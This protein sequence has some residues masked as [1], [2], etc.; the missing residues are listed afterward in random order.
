MR[1]DELFPLRVCINL[2]RRP[3]RWRRMQRRFARHRL[4]PVE[5]FPAVDG[6]ALGAPAGWTDPPGSYGCLL[7][8]LAVVRE[9]RRRGAP[10]V[11]IFEDDVVFHPEIQERF[12]AC[13]GQIPADWDMLLLG[14]LHNGEPVAVAPNL[15]RLT[16][17]YSTY[18][19]GLRHTLYDA[20]LDL[21]LR[22]PSPV[23]YN[24]TL[25]Q[26][27]FSCYCLMPHLAWVEDGYSDAQGTM[28]EHWYLRE[29]M[30]LNGREVERA[31]SRT[32]VI[33]PYAGGRADAAG[34]RLLRFTARH[35]RE[36]L[37]GAAVVVVTPRE[38]PAPGPGR[39]PAGCDL[40]R[41]PPGHPCEPATCCDLAGEALGGERPLLLV[42]ANGVC[43]QPP[44]LRAGLLMGERHDFVSP[45]RELV[46]LD[47]AATRAMLAG[48]HVDTSIHPVRRRGGLCGAGTWLISRSGLDALGGLRGA[49]S[50]RA[51]ARR[52]RQRLRVFEAPGKALRLHRGRVESR[53]T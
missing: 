5:R 45:F 23:D 31:Q 11:L 26:R 21:N 27:D 39:L 22:A 49:R 16:S 46:D 33:L 3:E 36:S 24:N 17:T 7:S 2:D 42:V 14:G 52:V 28:A 37:P 20:F 18:A 9:A 19:Y 6:A 34:L 1:L 41:L 51:L 15:V 30:V 10:Q 38:G 29:S 44:S 25:L 47:A 4:G 8:H 13:A 50:E 43:I 53:S 48:G 32:A 35:Y 12:A 40:L